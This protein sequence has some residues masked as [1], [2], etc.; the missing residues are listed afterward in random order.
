MTPAL[1]DAALE[2]LIATY[3]S[4][5]SELDAARREQMLDAVWAEGATYIDP[6]VR[7]A[8]KSELIEHI[9]RV[10]ARYPGAQVVRTSALDAHHARL[11]FA[12]AARLADGTPL[13]DGVDFAELSGDGKLH[14]IVGFFG[15]LAQV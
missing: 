11:R 9:A 14:G 2:Q 10:Q 8:G 15:P 3:C 4:A 7:A 1:A 6:S 12:W 13:V 5:W